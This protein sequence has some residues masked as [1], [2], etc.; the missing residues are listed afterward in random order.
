MSDYLYEHYKGK[1]RVL[2]NYDIE[3]NDFPSWAIQLVNISFFLSLP[4]NIRFVQ[5]VFIA[6]VQA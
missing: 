5:R 3:T 4:M 6:S 1:Y 2:A